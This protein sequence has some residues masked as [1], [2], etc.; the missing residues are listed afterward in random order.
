[1]EIVADE[2]DTRYLPRAERLTYRK[3]EQQLKTTLAGVKDAYFPGEHV[4]LKL[5]AQ[6]EKQVNTPAVALVSV[7][8][9]SL[10]KLADDKTDRAL[11]T[12]FLL[13]SE[14]RK[15]EDFENADV[16]LGAHPKA[17]PAVDLLLGTQG[18]RRFAEQDPQRFQ[19][20]HRG[21][22]PR[23]LAGLTAPSAR[24][25]TTEQVV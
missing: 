23:V 15:P 14:I 6:N 20:Q 4:N 19:Q 11:P 17:A 2:N 22:N 1:Y 25:N 24:R 12:H 5:K 8:D 3:G 21:D 9:L 18:W 7:V 10:I 13:T 16:L